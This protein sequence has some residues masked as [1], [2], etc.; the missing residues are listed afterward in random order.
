[1]PPNDPNFGGT[2]SRTPLD[3]KEGKGTGFVNISRILGAN[4]NNKLANTVNT[5]I[6]NQLGAYN[7]Q[8][9]SATQD[10]NER[11]QKEHQ[12][13]GD[14]NSDIGNT[15]NTVVAGTP[16]QT[17]A[18]Y[19][20][21]NWS[22][23]IPPDPSYG[24][25]PP[26]TTTGTGSF[27]ASPY[28]DFDST[29]ENNAYKRFEKYRSSKYE[30]PEQ[31]DQSAMRDLN[32]RAQ[33]LTQLQ[34]TLS[35]STKRGNLVGQFINNPYYNKQHQS[36]DSL[37]YGMEPTNSGITRTQMGDVAGRLS[38]AANA[39]TSEASTNKKYFANIG[40][41]I[42]RKADEH[43]KPITEKWEQKAKEMNNERD[44]LI[45]QFQMD[46][47]RD[48]LSDDT[49]S[50]L[51]LT[52]GTE[53]Y[54][55]KSHLLDDPYFT[56]GQDNKMENIIGD[57]DRARLRALQMLKG[58]TPGLKSTTEALTAK[59]ITP[60]RSLASRTQGYLG[61][62]AYDFRKD[63]FLGDAASRGTA[64]QTQLDKG[65]LNMKEYFGDVATNKIDESDLGVLGTLGG[66]INTDTTLYQYEEP[67]NA[68]MKDFY[69]RSDAG[70]LNA[71][72]GALADL[73]KGF[74]E[75]VV[76]P[77]YGKD[78]IQG[79]FGTLNTLPTTINRSSDAKQ[80][81][82]N[83]LIQRYHEAIRKAKTD[84]GARQ[85]KI[86]TDYGLGERL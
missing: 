53:T 11:A 10:F 58:A 76:Q 20:S 70:N 42:V 74:E 36:L 65:G 1:M 77:W 14:I 62:K 9:A 32:A 51:G 75:R 61:N 17:E 13:Y 50:R 27:G 52:R 59:E 45:T 43:A 35:D 84:L 30:G 73:E 4:R 22:D 8:L 79:S 56:K 81:N 23:M 29:N 19:R 54:G 48:A 46:L 26:G 47:E 63:A 82:L 78:Y 24:I 86:N 5:G 57:Y 83:N 72:R 21:Q 66:N 18:L 67:I 44:R 85:S 41:D 71:Q 38:T 7:N 49:L 15:F 80:N 25:N 64:A 69:K 60:S 3:L 16:E 34:N 39:A 33:G 55:L 2:T 31:L 37:I 6:S 40:G 12:R 68:L 28:T